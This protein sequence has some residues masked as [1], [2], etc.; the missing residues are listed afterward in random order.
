LTVN[1]C[2]R[3]L[4]GEET[5]KIFAGTQAKAVEA[6]EMDAWHLATWKGVAQAR[7]A[8]LS[9]AADYV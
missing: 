2:I 8:G 7:W 9:S 6:T 5:R 3:L 1:T 4:F